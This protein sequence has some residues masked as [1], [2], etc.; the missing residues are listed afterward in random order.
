MSLQQKRQNQVSEN[1]NKDW[2]TREFAEVVQLNVQKMVQFL[3]D[4]DNTVRY[5]LSVLNEKLTKLEKSLE[6]CEL[7]LR[8]TSLPMPE[9]S[10]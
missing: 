1:V 5:R 3:N 4:F 7:E 6:L 10:L 9:D 2:E 8:Y